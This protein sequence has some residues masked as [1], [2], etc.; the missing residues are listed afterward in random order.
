MTLDSQCNP[1]KEQWIWRDQA[2]D[3]SLY[4]K[5]LVLAQ[6]EQK[7]RSVDRIGNPEKSPCT[8]GSVNLPKAARRLFKNDARKTGE[9]HAKEWKLNTP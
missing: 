9:L 7:Y 5:A 2:R 6:Q 1:E 8:Y 4:Y 3:F